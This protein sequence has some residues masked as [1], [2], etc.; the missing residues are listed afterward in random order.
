MHAYIFDKTD[1]NYTVDE[2]LLVQDQLL[3]IDV[4]WALKDFQNFW[5][6]FCI[7]IG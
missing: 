4:R 1:P 6:T 5:L 7:L 3:N 2:F